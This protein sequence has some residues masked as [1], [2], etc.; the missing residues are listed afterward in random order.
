M[1][2]HRYERD[3]SYQVHYHHVTALFEAPPSFNA[4]GQSRWTHYHTFPDSFWL[5]KGWH[6]LGDMHIA[7]S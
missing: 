5:A 2:C 3:L 7:S 1:L 6:Q 4:K